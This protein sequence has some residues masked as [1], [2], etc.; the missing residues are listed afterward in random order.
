MARN[1]PGDED[2]PRRF[3]PLFWICMLVL[4]EAAVWTL[5][6]AVTSSAVSTVVA[7]AVGAAF[8][9]LLRD[10]IWGADWRERMEA[11]RAR[12]RQR[13]PRR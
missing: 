11:E 9:F 6:S 10:R 13:Q 7:L 12:A 5:L 2:E 8:V 3:S 4:L 1:A